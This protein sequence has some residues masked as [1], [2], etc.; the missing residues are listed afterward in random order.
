MIAGIVNAHREAACRANQR[1]EESVL[2]VLATPKGYP[3]R[4]GLCCELLG[5]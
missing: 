2:L 3:E 1:G 5:V 4:G